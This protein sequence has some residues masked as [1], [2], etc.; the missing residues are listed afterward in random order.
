M[1]AL[2]ITSV[3]SFEREVVPFV[4]DALQEIGYV[5]IQANQ[6]GYN[7]QQ[8][9]RN[10]IACCAL[11]GRGLSDGLAQHVIE[12]Y[13]SNEVLPVHTEGIYDPSG[14]IPYFALACIRPSD[15]G[16][17]T[18]LFDARQ[19][20]KRLRQIDPG[21]ADVKV[22]YS[23]SSY[24]DLYTEHSLVSVYKGQEV[25]RYRT[26]TSHNTIVGDVAHDD[27]YSTAD[28]CV[29]SSLIISHTWVAGD[30]LIV[31]NN[32]TLHDR[33]PYVGRRKMLRVRYGESQNRVLTY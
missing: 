28:T 26:K 9:E 16:G 29:E 2:Q 1:Y 32:I 22:R 30:I 3:T 4:H 18:R 21:L 6:G 5:L 12:G 8:I 27:F 25:L 23:S 7:E 10:M 15:T 20:A 19:A 24:P 33:L 17:E 11:F 14:I 13:D 31:N